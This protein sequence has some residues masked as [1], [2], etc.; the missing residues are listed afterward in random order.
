MVHR[1]CREV[2]H[3]C[4]L[5]GETKP[6]YQNL[7]LFAAEQWLQAYLVQFP[8]SA[9]CY[10]PSFLTEEKQLSQKYEVK[11]EHAEPWLYLQGCQW[12]SLGQVTSASLP[13][14]EDSQLGTSN[15]YKMEMFCFFS[16]SSWY[17]SLS[18]AGHIYNFIWNAAG[19]SQEDIRKTLSMT[20]KNKRESFEGLYIYF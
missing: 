14:P 16:S 13:L 1:A 6:R 4:F 2:F 9:R 20:L 11:T 12:T 10:M 17:S 5:C 3:S 8:L 15:I 7:C 18:N 19:Q